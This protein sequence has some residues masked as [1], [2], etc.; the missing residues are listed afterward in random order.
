[1]RLLLILFAI[2]L[3]G[4]A[5]KHVSYSGISKVEASG[6][7]AGTSLDSIVKKY[8]ESLSSLE[9]LTQNTEIKFTTVEY[10]DPD[11]L[12]NQYKKKETTGTIKQESNQT[13]ES[14]SNNISSEVS[15]SKK[16]S[17]SKTE[18]TQR[19]EET[20]SED[21]ETSIFNRLIVPLAVVAVLAGIIYVLWPK[22]K[23]N[24]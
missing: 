4:C 6:S 1:M 18:T 8:Q 22:I 20:A 3:S 15:V 7:F 2:L 17:I 12:G 24:W 23:R 16:D 10:S 11:S 9:K 21:K 5:D 19:V 13:K 14:E